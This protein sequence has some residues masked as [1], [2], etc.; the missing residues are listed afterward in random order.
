[1]S[2]LKVA[3]M[4]HPVLRSR[5]RE[6]DRSELKQAPLQRLIDDMIDTMHEY[7]GVGLAAPQIHEPLRIFV[8]AIAPENDDPLSPDDEPM[9]FI[10]PVIMPVG[11]EMVE[12]WE[13][14]LS[15]PD[16]RGRVPR[17]RSIKVTAMDR[18]GG[19]HQ[20]GS[21]PA[22][23]NPHIIVIGRTGAGVRQY[24]FAS[25]MARSWDEAFSMYGYVAEA[26]A[27][28]DDRSWVAFRLD[29]DARFHD[30]TPVDAAAVK[31][32]ID[33]LKDP[34]TKSGMR[35]F[36]EPVQSVEVMDPHTVQVRLQHPYAF[37]LHMLAAYR[38][39][40]VLYSPAATQKYTVE[41]RKQGK[42]GAV[43]GSPAYLS[44]EQI[45]AEPVTPQTD[46][47]SLGVLLYRLVTGSFP[48]EAEN[49][50]G[51]R[52]AVVQASLAGGL[53]VREVVFMAAMQVAIPPRAISPKG[54]RRRPT[55]SAVAPTAD[56][57]FGCPAPGKPS[58][59]PPCG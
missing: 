42:P 18:D 12:D 11:H 54:A 27:T 43:V 47:Y 28:A 23:I 57:I 6:I 7:H 34:A 55:L 26:V 5:A 32:S 48:V 10:N 59:R 2:L 24:S 50:D 22:G 52:A 15:I 31:F 58:A 1:M 8:A 36:Y 51:L 39:G 53:G 41:D 44:P 45:K 37:F 25:L 49:L 13:G 21:E 29:P 19:M 38:T 14:C 30:G 56:T 46:I 20:I 35:P 16:I 3:R 9:V 17:A 4:G 40:L 33:R